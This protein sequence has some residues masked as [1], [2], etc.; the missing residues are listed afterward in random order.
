MQKGW[1][2][3]LLPE[4]ESTSSPSGSNPATSGSTESPPSSA[5]G[6]PGLVT[7]TNVSTSA[8]IPTLSH[9]G[10]GMEDFED[11]FQRMGYQSSDQSW[12]TPQTWLEEDCSDPGYQL[13]TDAEIVDEAFGNNDHAESDSDDEPELDCTVVTPAQACDALDISLQ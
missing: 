2:K 5:D 6:L 9:D 8:C 4:K 12:Q 3:L 7:N 11:F 1:N 10:S 13:M